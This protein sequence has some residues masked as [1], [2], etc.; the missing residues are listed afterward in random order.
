MLPGKDWILKWGGSR[1]SGRRC[2]VFWCRVAEYWAGEMRS[3]GVRRWGFGGQVG[4][5]GTGRVVVEEEEQDL[6]DW[7]RGRRRTVRKGGWARGVKRWRT[8]GGGGWVG[9]WGS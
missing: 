6:Q 8:G 9:L 5:G 1:V 2:G 7:R 4:G 3:D